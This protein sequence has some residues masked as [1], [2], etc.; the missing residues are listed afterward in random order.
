MT[1]RDANLWTPLSMADAATFT[2]HSSSSVVSSLDVATVIKFAGYLCTEIKE[3]VEKTVNIVLGSVV[4]L[5]Q[6]AGP[7]EISVMS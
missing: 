1:G 5:T 7:I 6:R 3:S 4:P 2:F